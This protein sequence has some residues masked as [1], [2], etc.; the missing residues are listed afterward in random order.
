MLHLE[1]RESEHQAPA[2][3][4]HHPE[5]EPRLEGHAVLAED[6]HRVGAEGHEGRVAERDLT[7]VAE[8]QV[9][10]DGQDH[11][12]Q[13]QAQHV[14]LVLIENQRQEQAQREDRHEGPAA[15]RHYAHSS[16]TPQMPS[17]LSSSTAMR[18]TRAKA[19]RKW[20][21]M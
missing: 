16:F 7:G 11:V 19:S 4:E 10:T 14:E 3:R 15:A 21:E 2:E 6:R 1:G 18:M 12:D 20:L 9:E 8:G 13:R 5:R 17:G